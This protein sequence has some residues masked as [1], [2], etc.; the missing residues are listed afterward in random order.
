MAVPTITIKRLNAGNIR[1]HA[2]SNPRNGIAKL[3]HLRSHQINQ[4]EQLAISLGITSI[5]MLHLRK[6]RVFGLCSRKDHGIVP[7]AELADS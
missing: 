7:L 3:S 1:Q 5:S 4:R 2:D 6:P